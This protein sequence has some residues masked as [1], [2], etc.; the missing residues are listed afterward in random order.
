VRDSV[1]TNTP[2]EW[3]RIHDLPDYVYFDHSIHVAK[4]IGCS[5]CHGRVDQ[6]PITWRVNTLYMKWCLDCHRDP[7][8]LVRPRDKVFDMAWQPSRNQAAEGAKLAAQYHVDLSGHL[9]NCSTCHR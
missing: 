1:A 3:N 5:T 6:M 7:Q 2:L 8:R 4:G 9:T